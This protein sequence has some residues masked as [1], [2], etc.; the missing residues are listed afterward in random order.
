MFLKYHIFY[1][2]FLFL[3]FFTIFYYFLRGEDSLEFKSNIMPTDLKL[4]NL[5][6]F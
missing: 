5:Y 1:F 6:V 4:D 3:L 2:L